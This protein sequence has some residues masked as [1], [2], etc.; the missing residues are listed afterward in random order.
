M[1]SPR[2]SFSSSAEFI[3][4]LYQLWSF[5]LSFF[6]SAAISFPFCKQKDSLIM[7]TK[8]GALNFNFYYLQNASASL[9]MYCKL[10]SYQIPEPC[11]SFLLYDA[12]SSF[13]IS[14]W[15][16][17]FCQERSSL[18]ILAY[19]GGSLVFLS[20]LDFAFQFHCKKSWLLIWSSAELS[21]HY[22]HRRDPLHSCAHTTDPDRKGWGLTAR[23]VSVDGFDQPVP[24]CALV[25]E[26]A[27]AYLHLVH[28][29]IQSVIMLLPTFTFNRVRV[30][31]QC[32][33]WNGA[34]QRRG[35]DSFLN[36]TD[37]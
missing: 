11:P 27:N 17:H 10:S 26:K 20:N 23:T 5:C 31:A 1:R 35:P 6:L 8:H 21:G 4:H 19:C 32:Q 37:R 18:A 16:S 34:E 36:L 33:P 22:D 3:G 7:F 12:H 2:L 14:E 24:A 28:E 15:K 29:S 13:F 30:V 9:A 25:C